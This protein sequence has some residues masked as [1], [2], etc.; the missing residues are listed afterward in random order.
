M[1]KENLLG[2]PG[3]G[4]KIAMKTLDSGRIGIAAQVAAQ[5]D[6]TTTITTAST[7][8]D[9]TG[10]T[11]GCACLQSLGIGQ[12]AL[13]LAVKYSKERKAFGAPISKLYA[14]QLKLSQMACQLGA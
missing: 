5:T 11:G 14:I 12:A 8:D 13:E 4:F 1:P 10:S 7:S 9:M 3:E 2:K 6:T